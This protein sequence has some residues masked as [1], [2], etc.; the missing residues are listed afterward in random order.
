MIIVMVTLVMIQLQS[1]SR[2]FLVFS[3]APMG[4]IGVVAALLPSHTPMGFV[5][6]LGIVALAG[7]IVRNSVILITQIE[8][9]IA[10]GHAPWDA[11]IIATMHRTRPILLTAAA[12]IMG[13]VPI[14]REIFWGP[15]AFAVM[16]GLIAA[17][18]LTLWFLPALYVVWF[19][20]KP[21]QAGSR[22]QRKPGAV[23]VDHP[24]AAQ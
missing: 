5:A 1:M 3:V 22:D 23:V 9:E 7:M 13:M 6:I 17:T 21:S 14:S 12:A 18:L 10:H 4:V 16:G 19:R 15:M 8:T 24:A 20:I 2:T 11:V